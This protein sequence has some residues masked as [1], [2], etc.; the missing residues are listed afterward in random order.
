L[1]E[2][3]AGRHALTFGGANRSQCAGDVRRVA[4]PKPEVCDTADSAGLARLALE[5]QHIPAA[6]RLSLDEVASLVHR[7]D[8]DDGL[9]K[10]QRTL[11]IANGE[12]HV[13]QAV[14]LHG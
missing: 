5:D 11:R 4:Q 8:A 2:H 10:A 9:V 3:R 7:D 6:W 12:R 14:R 1:S 13:R